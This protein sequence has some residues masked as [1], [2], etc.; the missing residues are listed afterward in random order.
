MPYQ[1][2]YH[3]EVKRSDIPKLNETM[4]RRIKN[5][6]E[7]RLQVDPEKYS[8]PLRKT[9]KGYRKLRAG[10]YRIVLKI[11]N[12]DIFILGICHRKD[13]YKRIEKRVD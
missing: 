13:V 5:A 4:K 1:L 2:Y 11:E 3:H 6:I 7:K 8:E 12:K 9:L 10:D